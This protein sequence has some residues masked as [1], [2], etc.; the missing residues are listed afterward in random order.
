MRGDRFIRVFN[1]LRTRRRAVALGVGLLLLGC[2]AGLLL[3][4][5]EHSIEVMVPAGS[6]SQEAMRFLRELDFS[7]KVVLSFSQDDGAD[8]MELF[9]AVDRFADSLDSP[10]ILNVLET[11]DDK[12]LINDLSFFF[13]NMAEL[14][15]ARE[16]GMLEN[17]LT[18]AGVERALRRKYIQLLKPEGSFMSSLI[19]SDP[20]DLQQGM[21]ERLRAMS[22]SMGYNIR[23]EKGHLVSGDGQHVMMVLE[24]SVP[25]TDSK[26]AHELIGYL[27]QQLTQRPP[28]IHATIVCGHLHTIS[29][30][31]IIKRDIALTVSVAASAFILLFLLF[32]KDARANLVFLLPF[33]ALLVGINLSALVLGTLSSIMLG[34]GSV[35]AGIAVDYGIHVYIAVRRGTTAVESVRAV[36]RPLLMGALTTCGV[37]FALLF[38]SIPGCRQLGCLALISV[39]LAVCG[40]LFI[41]PLYLKHNSLRAYDLSTLKWTKKRAGWVAALFVVLLLAGLPAA[42]RVGFDGS[43]EQL[44]GT[45][46][47]IME[48]EQQFQ[49]IWGSGEVGQA[50]AAVASD[51]YQTAL[52]LNDCVYDLAVEAIG[53]DQVSSLSR[54]WKS[55]KTRDRN[56]RLWNAFWTPERVESLRSLIQEKGAQFGFA[57]DAFDPFFESLEQSGSAGGAADGNL[58]LSQMEKRFVQQRD[59]RTQVMSFFPDKP[60]YV[61]A[62]SAVQDRVPGMVLISRNA[63]SR[64]LAHDYTREFIRT[65]LIALVLVLGVSFVMLK[66]LRMTLIV[67]APAAAGVMGVVSVSSLLG[68]P[69]NV[70]NLLSGIIVIGLCIDYGI[71]YVHA[72]AHSLNLGTRTA[73]SLSAGTTLIGVGALMFARHPALFSVGLTLMCGITAGYV[74]SMLVVPALCRLMLGDRS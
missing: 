26:G 23:V 28:A 55:A 17:Q 73:I 70:M 34:F 4:P 40:A 32:F 58:I 52:E 29:N 53:A 25:F 57:A 7:A 50:I 61:E 46:Q 12:Q 45:E 6:R 56:R 49:K 37:F 11:V 15:G 64:I 1:R 3:V 44:D 48:N 5:L 71:F 2:A 68:R 13:G 31:R 54:I 72:Y 35:I 30:E 43:V 16:L 10:L 18:P 38:S 27:D 51:D 67:L 14:Y 65:S 36:A 8:R 74:T 47:Q 39:A 19:R 62:M 60:E 59:G 21:I 20:L 63:I 42:L 24:T 66:N 22:G 69:L 9:E 33:A 41:L